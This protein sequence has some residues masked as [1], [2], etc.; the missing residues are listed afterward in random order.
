MS[1]SWKFR[2]V[3]LWLAA[4]ALGPSACISIPGATQW[5]Q[6][7]DD[8]QDS[9]PSIKTGTKVGPKRGA[10]DSPTQEQLARASSINLQRM[11]P[12]KPLPPPEKAVVV[13]VPTPPLPTVLFQG[14]L[15]G[16]I[17]D[18]DPKYCFALLKGLDEQVKLVAQGQKIGSSADSATLITIHAKEVTIQLGE[19]VQTLKVLEEP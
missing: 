17:E 9:P 15:L 4:A 14:K 18:S 2:N 6:S 1:L 13:A 5:L 10:L 12:P 8:S 3:I 7:V 16:T 19:Q 11:N